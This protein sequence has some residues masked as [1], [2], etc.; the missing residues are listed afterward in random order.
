MY[1]TGSISL[2]LVGERSTYW[3]H[4]YVPSRYTSFLN[5]R[6][7][8]LGIGWG[9]A[10]PFLF[11]SEILDNNVIIWYIVSSSSFY[12]FRLFFLYS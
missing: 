4:G 6:E 11:V 12:I 5:R 3:I 9:S 2:D 8:Y 1:Y 7:V 10:D